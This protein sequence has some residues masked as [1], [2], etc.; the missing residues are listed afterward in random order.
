MQFPVKIILDMLNTDLD[1]RVRG[2]PEIQG[3]QLRA[4]DGRHVEGLGIEVVLQLE[5]QYSITE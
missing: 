5:Q 1:V 3:G 4:L 2:P